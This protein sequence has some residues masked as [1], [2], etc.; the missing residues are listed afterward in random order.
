MASPEDKVDSAEKGKDT[1]GNLED[2]LSPLP[3]S[4]GPPKGRRQPQYR[5]SE[6]ATPTTPLPYE[7]SYTS[8]SSV[9]P[10]QQRTAYGYTA[11][12]PLQTPEPA[13]P[14][15]HG[16]IY[17]VNS[18]LQ[19]M[20]AFHTG[21]NFLAGASPSRMTPIPPPSP[22]FP[23]ASTTGSVES[24]QPPVLPYMSP[25]LGSNGV[26]PAYNVSYPSPRQDSWNGNNGDRY[27]SFPLNLNRCSLIL[28]SSLQQ[29]K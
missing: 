28:C 14:A 22:L 13:S 18:F 23:R 29:L 17:D 19:P 2:P 15:T 26:A 10:Q 7:Y 9:T 3:S 21:S 1:N 25:H 11:G 20:G 6:R 5:E 8:Y 16:P 24:G 4:G 27:E 12:Y